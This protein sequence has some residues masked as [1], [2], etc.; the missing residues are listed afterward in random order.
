MSEPRLRL[1]RRGYVVFG[2]FWFALFFCADKF[3]YLLW[4]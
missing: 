2:I 3:G 1:T 4:F